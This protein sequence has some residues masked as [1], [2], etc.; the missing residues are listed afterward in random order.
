MRPASEI[1]SKR[2]MDSKISIIQEISLSQGKKDYQKIR[3]FRDAGYEVEVNI[4]AVDK[5][6][7][8]LSCIERD[9]KLLELGY[10]PRPVARMNHD[11]MYE[12]FLQ[13]IIE[14]DRNEMASTTNVYIRGNTLNQLKLVYTTGD[15][16]YASAQ[17]AIIAERAKNRR[18]ILGEPQIFLERISE[19][20]QKIE[21]M[22]QD[23]R[24]RRNYLEQLK[25]IEV[26]FLNELAFER[27]YND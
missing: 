15:T 17:E 27:S 16:T 3:T 21:M 18:K 1:I 6:E 5:Y 10:D 26:E 8:F 13:E 7:S 20:R 24:L 25:Q 19:A 14:I 12:S 4:V 23:E 2:L 22:I 9:I 11:R